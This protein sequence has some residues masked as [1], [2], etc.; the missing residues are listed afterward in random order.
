MLYVF[1]PCIKKHAYLGASWCFWKRSRFLTLY[2][3][4]PTTKLKNERNKI[5]PLKIHQRFVLKIKK[6]NLPRFLDAGFPPIPNVLPWQ[7]SVWVWSS[8]DPSTKKKSF[9]RN[10]CLVERETMS[11]PPPPGGWGHQNGSSGTGTNGAC[12]VI[13]M[14]FTWT[15]GNTIQLIQVL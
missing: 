12:K 15:T 13:L 7:S 1:F 2:F 10:C 14:V 5:E 11:T 8:L 9:D 6:K 3:S 4:L